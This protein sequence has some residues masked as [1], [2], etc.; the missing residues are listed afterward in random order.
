MKR[1]N[2]IFDMRS[3]LLGLRV[4]LITDGRIG[5]VVGKAERLGNRM[6]LVPVIVE[7]STRSELWPEPRIEALPIK[8]QHLSLGGQY[9]APAGYPLHAKP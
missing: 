1:K 3:P 4:R 8:E 2:V 6:A 7:A 5:F 9:K